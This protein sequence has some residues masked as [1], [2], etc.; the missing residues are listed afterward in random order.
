MKKY[1]LAVILITLFSLLPLGAKASAEDNVPIISIL[2]VTEDDKVTIETEN[3]PASRDFIARMGQFGTQGVDGIK[4]GTVNSGKG[5]NLKFTFTIPPSLQNEN[6]I[7]IRLESINGSYYAYNW[8]SNTTFGT[9]SGGTPADEVAVQPE[10]IVAS[11]KEDTQ[12]IIKGLGFPSDETFN[13][14][15]GE[16]G[17]KGIGGVQVDTLDLGGEATFIENFNIPSSLQGETKLD[18]RFESNESDLVVYTTFENQ[19]GASGGTSEDYND[20]G[21]SDIP[22][23]AILSIKEGESVTLKTHNFPAGRDFQVLMGEMGTRGIDGIQVTTFSSGTGGS[24][25]KTFDIPDALK[26]EYQI[27]IRLQT[28]DGVFFAY[29]WFYNDTAGNGGNGTTTPGYTGI[30]TFAITA[31]DK[32]DMVT[33]KTHNFPANIDFKVLMGKMGTKGVG[34]TTVTQINSGSGGVFTKTFDIPASLAGEERIAIRL[35]ALSGEY[36]AYNW[37]FNATYP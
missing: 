13:V 37:F 9:H 23:I 31:I 10:I 30:P 7:V 21:A 11:V 28:A 4:V 29:N 17:S 20:G 27:A 26:G 33:I 1:S 19:T 22:T 2:G 12:V 5:G 6:K 35:E 15:L 34:G 24:L 14:L 3:F 32:G 16:E 36:F 25:T 18:I 8:F